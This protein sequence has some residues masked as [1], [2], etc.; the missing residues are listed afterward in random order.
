MR[1]GSCRSGESERVSTETCFA[2]RPWSLGRSL[3]P[4]SMIGYTFSVYGE[5]GFRCGRMTFSS[6]QSIGCSARRTATGSRHRSFTTRREWLDL[7]RDLRLLTSV[8]GEMLTAGD[9]ATVLFLVSLP[10]FID[11][12]WHVSRSGVC[13]EGPTSLLTYPV[14]TPARPT[15]LRY[16]ADIAPLP[17]EGERKADDQATAAGGLAG[18]GKGRYRPVNWGEF[19]LGRFAGDYSNQGEEVQISH[20]RLDA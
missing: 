2:P 3:L 17:I 5:P 10:L 13:S 12:P 16:H 7:P 15:A 11:L 9:L 1:S 19:R 6:H 20:Y 14:F 4:L 18:Q 8:L